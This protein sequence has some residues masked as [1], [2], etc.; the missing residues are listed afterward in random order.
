[1]RW[2]LQFLRGISS[3]VH[4]KNKH[5]QNMS[6][7][8]IKSFCYELLATSLHSP[9]TTLAVPATSSKLMHITSLSLSLS[10]SVFALTIYHPR[11]PSL[12]LF[13]K[14]FPPIHIPSGSGF[15]L[16]CLGL[17]PD[18][19]GNGFS[20]L[21]TVS[22]LIFLRLGYVCCPHQRYVRQTPEI[23]SNGDVG[24]GRHDAWA[25]TQHAWV[26]RPA[27]H[28]TQRHADSRQLRSATVR[29][30]NNEATQFP[31]QVSITLDSSVITLL[32]V[33]RKKPSCVTT[34]YL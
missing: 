8:G 29:S 26:G 11:R 4:A 16:D 21:I 10:L 3:V 14:S 28:L 25:T 12:R 9:V 24:S 30:S 20:I 34:N 6:T 7:D 5:W 31:T 17:G 23:K 13:H 33:R 15:P 18:L 19:V 1:M 2:G 22:S 27:T 32:H